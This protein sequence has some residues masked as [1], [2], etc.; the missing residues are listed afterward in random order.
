MMVTGAFVAAGLIALTVLFVAAVAVVAVVTSG[1][2]KTSGRPVLIASIAGIGGVFM[3][4]VLLIAG[5]RG[6]E[7][8]EVTMFPV[9]FG[10]ITLF[11][12]PT[13]LIMAMS[14]TGRWLLLL[15]V[16][17]LIPFALLAGSWVTAT[18]VEMTSTTE[19]TSRPAE[20]YQE[21]VAMAP[22]DRSALVEVQA[23][24]ERPSNVSVREEATGEEVHVPLVE[25][26][27][28]QIVNSRPDVD[29]Q[30]PEEIEQPTFVRDAKY[31]PNLR[32]LDASTV[33]AEK[34]PK[35]PIWVAQNV[36]PPAGGRIL[37]SERFGS[38]DEARDQLWQQITSEVRVAL[39]T[40]NPETHSW[41]PLLP[42]LLHSGIVRR[43]CIAEYPIE[44]GEFTT[45][46]YEVTWYCNV[47][48]NE[49]LATLEAT[50]ESQIVGGRNQNVLWAFF[51][52][53][54]ALT[55]LGAAL[56][57]SSHRAS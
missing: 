24:G 22:Q 47:S 23:E 14:K 13:V 34:N 54:A 28:E 9:A 44:V 53:T 20:T 37:R 56:R 55:L 35:L 45:S 29:E 43:E 19:A 1:S 36:A 40:R 30:P 5:I 3:A 12:I 39:R 16:G 15:G 52:A 25:V 50:W 31:D 26:T 7:N 51:G 27:P 33:P 49:A 32:Q 11:V 8:Q 21:A 42:E 48:D 6:V 57:R 46:A 17:V 18:R 41:R 10:L 38:I 2:N 4:I